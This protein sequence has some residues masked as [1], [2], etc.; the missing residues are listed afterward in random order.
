MRVFPQLTTGAS[1]L[2]PLTKRSRQR[3]VVNTL[4]DGG[5]DVFADPDAAALGW[6]LR[7]IGLTTSEW[8]AIEALFQASSGMWLAF[9]FLDP[10]ANLLIRSEEFGS[11]AWTNGA[12]IQLTTGITDPLSTTRATRAINAGQGAG[13]LAQTL[14]V[15]GNFHYCLSVWARTAG[16]SSLTLVLSTTGGSAAKTFPLSA[17]WTRLSFQGVLG[18]T[19]TSVTFGVQIEPGGS[20]DLF[21]M[22]VEAQP[23]PS[24]YKK[25]GARGGV[26]AK[27][28]FGED[29][30]AVTA[31]GTDVY[32]AMIRI[33]NTET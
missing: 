20:V 33:V 22:Q 14:S 25:T 28:R 30:I 8:N 5:T 31:R 11:T 1:G 32:D 26:Y 15:P 17:Q 29:R 7:A 27:A 18:F 21:G 9:T 4:G 10:T 12:L 24:D 2:Y 16:G 3:T 6:E 23:A 19:T 13:A